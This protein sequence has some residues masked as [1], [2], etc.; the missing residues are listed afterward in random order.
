MITISFFVALVVYFIFL[1]IWLIFGLVNVAHLVSTGTFTTTSFVF[2]LLF[3]VYAVIVLG[4]TWHFLGGIDWQ[5]P[6]T[7][8]DSTWFSS[9]SNAQPF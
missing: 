6:L 8:W 2:T 3:L 9:G 7:V 4:F 1:T 5:Q